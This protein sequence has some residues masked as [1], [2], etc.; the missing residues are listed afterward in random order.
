M[1]SL[2]SKTLSGCL[3][4]LL[5]QLL[6]SPASAADATPEPAKMYHATAEEFAPLAQAVLDLLQSGAA[7]SFA[8]SVTPSLEDWKSI[9][10]TNLPAQKEDPL[11]GFQ[12]SGPFLRGKLELGAKQVLDRAAAMHLDFAKGDWHPR[13]VLPQRF[14]TTRHPGLQA[15]NEALPS[16][17]ELAVVLDSGAGAA[18]S[19]NGAFMLALRG[20]LKFPGGWRCTEGI[21]WTDFPNTVADEKTKRELAL[22]NKISSGRSINGQDD[23]ALLKL[24]ETLVRFVREGDVNVFEQEA[25]VTAELMWGQY[26]KSP[27]AGPSRA[28]LEAQMSER[29]KDQMDIARA[30]LR[31]LADAGVTFKDADIAIKEVT[32]ERVQSQGAASSLSGL[33]G[34]HFVLK[35]AVKLS[36]KSKTGVSLTGE[37]ILGANEVMR[38]E[39]EWRVTDNLHW[40]QFPEGILGREEVAKLNL[41]AYVEEHRALPPGTTAPAIGF[42]TLDGEKHMTLAELKGKVVVLDFWA[43]WCGPCQQP[44]AELQKLVA[45]HPDWKDRV[46]VMPLS[47]DDEI[48]TARKHLEQRDWTNTFN[49]WAG[50]GGWR[51]TPAKTFRV[52]GIPTTYI[53]DSHGMII[54]AGHPA[55]M[56]IG[57]EVSAL[58]KADDQK[59]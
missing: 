55:S 56:D 41:D 43:T 9:L 48:R 40:K 17:E 35:L 36:G 32:V 28:D 38:F 10:S 29:A 25:F 4:A 21:A 50:D 24:G 58:L 15:E 2:F 49:V 7:V 26:R 44:M 8:R 42:I 45:A 51:S 54:R 34:S 30:S 20:L 14:A 19:T 52:S 27:R 16:V 39:D 59:P 1:K 6:V 31:Q 23:P 11:A 12:R 47:I 13:V 57:G 33:N 22:L 46:T 37:Y 18:G 53:I 3:A 5:Q